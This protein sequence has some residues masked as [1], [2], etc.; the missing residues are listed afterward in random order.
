M[1]NTK[2]LGGFSEGL[3]KNKPGPSSPESS[4]VY[5]RMQ[6]QN[7]NK[8]PSKPKCDCCSGRKW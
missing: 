5:K 6:Q 7:K 2:G 1:V 4:D 3:N 8:G